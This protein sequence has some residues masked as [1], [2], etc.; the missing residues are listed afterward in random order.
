MK[1]SYRKTDSWEKKEHSA[2]RLSTYEHAFLPTHLR[3]VGSELTMRNAHGSAL[4]L[5]T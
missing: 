5:R 3:L 1:L 2:C 4:H